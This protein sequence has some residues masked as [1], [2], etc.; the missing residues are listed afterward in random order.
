MNTILRASGARTLLWLLAASIPAVAF[1]A[2]EPVKKKPAQAYSVYHDDGDST[3]YDDPHAN[4]PFADLNSLSRYLLKIA[5]RM[6]KYGM[7]EALP[8]IT[9]IPRHDLEEK[10][11]ADPSKRCQVAAL[12][13]PER[14]VMLA[15]DLQ[16][17]TNLFHR[18][19]LFHELVHYMQEVGNELSAAAPCER[20]YQR[21]VEAYALQNRFLAQSSSPDRVSYAGA[22]PTC[23]HVETTQTHRAKPVKAP[24]VND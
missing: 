6:S 10:V 8:M 19:I 20:W 11:C 22:R 7:P 15:E 12:Y 4:A 5:M 18:S 2:D 3:S 16:P 1:A 13:E 21:E 14:G 23:E 17:E 24:G 9:R